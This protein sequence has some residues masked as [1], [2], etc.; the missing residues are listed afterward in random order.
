MLL[1]CTVAVL[2]TL[3]PKPAHV[4]PGAPVIRLST[5][6]SAVSSVSNAGETVALELVKL[7]V[8]VPDDPAARLAG[9]KAIDAPIALAALTVKLCCTCGAAFQLESPA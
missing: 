8:S 9:E 5:L 3:A 4:P 1:N 6:V 7:M 2:G